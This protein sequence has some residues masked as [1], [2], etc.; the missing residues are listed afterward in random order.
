[1]PSVS[2][3][4]DYESKPE[5]VE[6]QVYGHHLVQPDSVIHDGLDDMGPAATGEGRREQKGDSLWYGYCSGFSSRNESL[7]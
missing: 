4:N 7:Y 2:P 1:M 6:P 3:I 5:A